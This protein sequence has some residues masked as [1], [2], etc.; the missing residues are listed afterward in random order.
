MLPVGLLGKATCSN[1]SY[2][3][4]LIK[5]GCG[6][7]KESRKLGIDIGKKAMPVGGVL[8]KGALGLSVG[9]VKGLF[10]AGYESLRIMKNAYVDLRDGTYF[11]IQSPQNSSVR[12]SR[13]KR[14]YRRVTRSQ[15]SLQASQKSLQ[16][17]Q[18][19]VQA[20]QKSVQASQKSVQASQKGVQASQKSVQAT[21]L[22]C[23]NALLI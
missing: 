16:A 10:T 12:G 23:L 11:H 19:S 8:A 17:S 3:S 2:G 22:T 6:L 21:L 9:A 20:S 7:M 14:N 1:P 5:K 18:K 4:G 13:L 15:K